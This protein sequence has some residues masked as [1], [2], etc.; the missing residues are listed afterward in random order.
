VSATSLSVAVLAGGPSS[1]AEVSRV[2]AAAVARALG[3]AGHRARVYELDGALPAALGAAEV[4]VVFPALHGRLGEDGAVQGMLE[5]LNLPYV[6]AGVLASALAA[7]KPDAKKY[8][9]HAGLPVAREV[10]VLAGEDLDVA[11]ARI[12]GE[13]GAAV[14][15]KPADSGSAI[16]VSRIRDADPDAVLVEALRSALGLANAALVEPFLVGQEVTC[17]V[18]EDDEGRAVALPPTL[19]VSKAADWYDFT[20]R[21]RAGGS[22]HRCP[23]PFAKPIIAA[24]Q[25]IAVA[26]HRT[27]GVRDLSRAD[28]VV[29]PDSR[30]EPVTLLEVN[31]LPGMT[32]TSLFPEAAAVAGFDFVTL[33]AGLVKRA[34]ARPRRIHARAVPMP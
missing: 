21:Y 6:G 1:E 25:Q 3:E 33:C 8:F 5:V 29:C 23:A 32:E 7:S 20:S 10:V 12:R 34:H 30:D 17:G 16:G 4:D 24:I 11:A 9:R 27:L 2:S 18:L 26:A 13:L 15:V 22:E 31:T 28:F 14:V 19:I